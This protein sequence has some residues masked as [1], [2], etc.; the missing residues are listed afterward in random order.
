MVT[1]D[2]AVGAELRRQNDRAAFSRG[3]SDGSARHRCGSRE[4]SGGSNLGWLVARRVTSLHGFVIIVGACQA[5]NGQ[6]DE[7]LAYLP[8]LGIG[9]RHRP[10]GPAK[11]QPCDVALF[12]CLDG[13]G[14]TRRIPDVIVGALADNGQRTRASVVYGS[15]VGSHHLST[16]ESNQRPPSGWSVST[17]GDVDGDG[18]A[19]IAAP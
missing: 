8:R 2:E 3:F 10:L 4:R 15:A 5:L 13:R 11:E 1:A 16:G 7:G 17:A 19:T 9:P 18:F 12:S 6:A 14:R